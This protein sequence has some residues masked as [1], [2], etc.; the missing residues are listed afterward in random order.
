MPLTLF[1]RISLASLVFASVIIQGQPNDKKTIDDPNSVPARAKVTFVQFVGI[2]DGHPPPELADVAAEYEGKTFPDAAWAP[3]FG[4]RVRDIFQKHGF[5]KAE[6]RVRFDV[7]E[8]G[9]EVSPIVTIDKGIQY[10]LKKI[11]ISGVKVF[12]ATQLCPLFLLNP[13]E[14]FDVANIRFGVEALRKLYGSKGYINFTPVPETTVNGDGTILLHIDV[15][16]GKQ[17]HIGKVEIVGLSKEKANPLLQTLPKNGSVYSS[18][19]FESWLE[20]SRPELPVQLRTVGADRLFN[21]QENEG[22]GTIDITIDLRQ[23]E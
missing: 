11:E 3:G 12:P 13:G 5:F 14:I 6:V 18:A 19:E 8:P 9:T 21:I 10:R 4:E 2:N 15:D 20:A 7:S 23:S 1:G 22:A 16:E 17:F